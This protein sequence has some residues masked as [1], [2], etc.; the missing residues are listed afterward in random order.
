MMA[1]SKHCPINDPR[2]LMYGMTLSE[3]LE[4]KQVFEILTAQE[5]AIHL[6]DKAETE[7]K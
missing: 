5:Y 4:M 1:L 3:F 7:N 2:V 6:D